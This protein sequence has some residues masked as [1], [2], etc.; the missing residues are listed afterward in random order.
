MESTLVQ[1]QFNYIDV[2]NIPEWVIDRFDPMGEQSYFLD[3]VMKE[4][5]VRDELDKIDKVQ[6]KKELWELGTYTDIQLNN[7]EDNLMRILWVGLYNHW[8]EM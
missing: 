7:H 5:D 3:E 4:K 1:V 8:D 2:L 6:L